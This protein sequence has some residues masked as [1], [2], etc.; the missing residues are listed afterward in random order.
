M[1]ATALT[2]REAQINRLTLTTRNAHRELG[3]SLSVFP[4]DLAGGTY[5]LSNFK[6]GDSH[7]PPTR[8]WRSALT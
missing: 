1:L 8:V 7:R 3:I 2:N 6:T 4:T 5:V